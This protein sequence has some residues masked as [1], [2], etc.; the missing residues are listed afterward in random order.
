MKRAFYGL[1]VPGVVALAA[2]TVIGAEVF[3]HKETARYR[4]S[5]PADARDTGV[6]DFGPR[7]IFEASGTVLP[8]LYN[9]GPLIVNIA[10]LEPPATSLETAKEDALKTY[11]NYQ[12][13]V[14]E[15]DYRHTVKRV[16]LKSGQEAYY[17]AT[18][19]YRSSK[20]LYQNRYD[21]VSYSAGDSKGIVLS[22]SI[23]HGDKTYAVEKALDFTGKLV[24]PL[25][26]RFE[27]K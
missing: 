6:R 16:K 12:D 8:P 27:F 11:S 21:L 25:F 20:G 19:F 10:L 4:F 26:N 14:W 23:Q 3:I 2:T 18:R 7:F 22:I 17:L 1:F 5:V 13:R 24:D 15:P 9:D